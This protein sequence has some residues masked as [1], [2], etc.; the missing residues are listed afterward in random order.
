MLVREVMTRRAATV[1]ADETLEAAARKMKELGVGALPVL[2]RGQLAGIV[3]DRDVTVR[4][5]ATGADPRRAHV[6]EA[7]TAQVVACREDDDVEDAARRMEERAVRRLM[8]LDRAGDLSGMLSVEDLAG[9][10]M[11]L[12]ADVLRHSRD[13][14]LPLR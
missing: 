4:G 6:R 3:T 2:D 1:G 14:E 8:V 10:S 12:A 11:A 13:P 5:V 7:M 9:A